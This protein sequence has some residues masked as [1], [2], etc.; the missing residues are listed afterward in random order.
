VLGKVKGDG[1]P[2]AQPEAGDEGN[3]VLKV[4]GNCIYLIWDFGSFAGKTQANI[5]GCVKMAV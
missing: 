2:D 5:S 4:H 1:F 3:F